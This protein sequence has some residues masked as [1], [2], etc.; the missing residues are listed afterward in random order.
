MTK[1]EIEEI[2]KVDLLEELNL[3][4]LSF[5]DKMLMLSQITEIVF[6]NVWIRIL[7][8]LKDDQLSVLEEKIFLNEFKTPE[9]FNNYLKN[10]IP[11]LDDLIKEEIANYKK[12]LLT[13]F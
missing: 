5:E 12:I 10:L 4:D 6:Q 7:E 13:K 3:K 9:E 2:L 1:Q 8:I 11:N